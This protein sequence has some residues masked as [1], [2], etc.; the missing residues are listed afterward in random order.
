MH[1]ALVMGVFALLIGIALWPLM[2][3]EIP[4]LTDTPNHLARMHV[5]ATIDGDPDLQTNYQVDWAIVPKRARRI[6]FQGPWPSG[7]GAQPGS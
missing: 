5:L 7:G 1:P 4:P 3:V 2:L 6:G